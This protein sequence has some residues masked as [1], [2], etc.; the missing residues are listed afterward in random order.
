MKRTL[1]VLGLSL[2]MTATLA[3]AQH[4]DRAEREVHITRGPEITD[5]R[6]DSAVIR[7]TT[8]KDGANRVRYRIAGSNMPWK[9][10]YHSGGGTE[11]E[12]QLTGLERGRTYEWQILT[13][14]GDVRTSG[15]FEAR[16]GY[17]DHDRY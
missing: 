13:Q 9:T 17:H 12:L 14:D 11:H 8:D 10:A 1:S 5:V 15:Q 16:R 3:L 6:G 2:M 4:M 7:W